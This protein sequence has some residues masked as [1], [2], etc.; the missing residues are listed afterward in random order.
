MAENP[1]KTTGPTV[2]GPAD[3]PDMGPAPAGEAQVDS[4]QHPHSSYKSQMTRANIV[5][6]VLFVGGAATVYAL[7]LRKGPAEA[8]AEQKLI[9]SSVDSAILRLKYAPARGSNALNARNVA[10]DLLSSFSDRIVKSQVPLDKLDKNPFK[11]AP[12]ARRASP[13]ITEPQPQPKQ[14]AKTPEQITYEQAMER[15]SRLRLQSVMMDSSGSAAIISN[16]LL[17]VGQQM[18]G[19]TVK[20]IGPK[21]VVLTWGGQEF[22]LKMSLSGG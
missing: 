16:N 4:P 8:S 20:R 12:L 13:P 15:L 18:E 22:V 10:R 11:F 3:L 14:P 5:L 9:E 17:T 19:F 2:D 6:A 1:Y 7:S 21:S